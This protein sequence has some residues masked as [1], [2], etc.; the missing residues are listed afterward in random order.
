MITKIRNRGTRFFQVVLYRSSSFLAVTTRSQ[1]VVCVDVEG[2]SSWQRNN[3]SDCDE[4]CLSSRF[5]SCDGVVMKDDGEF[6]WTTDV[7]M[8]CLSTVGGS[9]RRLDMSTSVRS[10]LVTCSNCHLIW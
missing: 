9:K 6:W 7:R 4:A 2:Q 8:T 3:I 5:P 10:Y 1:C